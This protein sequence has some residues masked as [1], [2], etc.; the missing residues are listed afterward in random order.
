MNFCDISVFVCT[1]N[2]MLVFPRS[3]VCGY[4]RAFACIGAFV[5]LKMC[6]FIHTVDVNN[7]SD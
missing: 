1:T 6:D 4:S 7:I 2:V 5:G 3:G